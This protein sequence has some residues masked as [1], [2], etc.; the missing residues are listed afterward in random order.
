MAFRRLS[1]CKIHTT[2]RLFFEAGL[3]IRAIAR[4]LRVS[5]EVPAKAGMGEYLRRAQVAGLSWP[6]PE[7]MDERA[8][9]ARLFPGVRCPIGC[10]FT[11]SG[12]ARGSPCR[13][14]GRSTRP[15]LADP[16]GPSAEPPC[17]A[18]PP[19]G[20]A[21]A[22]PCEPRTPRSARR[23]P[24]QSP[25]SAI[26]HDAPAPAHAPARLHAPCTHSTSMGRPALAHTAARPRID[27]D[28]RR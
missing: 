28:A 12:G 7:G 17:S 6:L 26:R 10:T 19:R 27:P 11:P 9:E 8:L 22:T 14:C 13:C 21:G 16:S 1:M 4:T 25:R 23:T 20:E 24:G 2:L 3:S 15:T 18:P 5:P